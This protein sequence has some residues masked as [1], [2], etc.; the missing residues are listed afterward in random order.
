[1]R[2]TTD[3]GSYVSGPNQPV[4]DINS[5]TA[6][7]LLRLGVLICITMNRRIVNWKPRIPNTYYCTAQTWLQMAHKRGKTRNSA[8]RFQDQPYIVFTL[9]QYP[10]ACCC[11]H[12]RPASGQL[13]VENN[14]VIFDTKTRKCSNKNC[15]LTNVIPKGLR[16]FGGRKPVKS[17]HCHQKEAIA[18]ELPTFRGSCRL[19]P[20]N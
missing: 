9:L 19:L 15:N 18:V 1:M 17:R 7:A 10:T 2:I 3:C 12:R 20:W 16:M 5:K 4:C 14:D 8:V 11:S 13:R 6:A